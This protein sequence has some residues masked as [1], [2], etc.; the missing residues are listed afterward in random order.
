[1]IIDVIFKRNPFGEAP[2]PWRK[3]PR[4]RSKR[5]SKRIQEV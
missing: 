4:G 5:R 2:K 3:K 1:M